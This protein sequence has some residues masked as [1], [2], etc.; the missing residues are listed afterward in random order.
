M[1]FFDLVR[2]R[3]SIRAFA[4]EPVEP[5]KLEKILEAANRAPSAGNLQAYEIYLLTEPSLRRELARAALEQ[6]FI[7]DAPIVLIFA[8]NPVRSEEKYKERGSRLY[9]LQDATI[10]C[11]FAM[12]AAT[13][14]GLATVWVGAFRDEAVCNIIGG[15]D[16]IRPVAILPVGYPAEEPSVTS[17]RDLSDIVHQV[18]D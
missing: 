14:L 2:A 10:A 16:R 7:A 4:S 1:D 3:Q 18:G 13:S 15:P 17:R 8:A 9:A 11:C 12:L 6:N 5:E